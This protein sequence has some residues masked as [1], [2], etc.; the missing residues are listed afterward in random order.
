MVIRLIALEIPDLLRPLQLR[1]APDSN[2][3]N[4][5]EKSHP[6]ISLASSVSRN[7]FPTPDRALRRSAHAFRHWC[8]KAVKGSGI[9]RLPDQRHR[10]KNDERAGSGRPER[11]FHIGR[12]TPG[13]DHP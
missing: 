1:S 4:W 2:A 7:K 8:R 6:L 10:L 12:A 3:L 9:S 11:R 5:L 13:A